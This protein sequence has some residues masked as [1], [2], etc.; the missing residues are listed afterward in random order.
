MNTKMAVSDAARKPEPELEP[1]MCPMDYSPV[2][3]SDGITY[4]NACMLL[5]ANQES[6]TEIFIVKE[7]RCDEDLLEHSGMGA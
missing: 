6:G 5:A 4:S 3:G 2:C 1:I 7:G